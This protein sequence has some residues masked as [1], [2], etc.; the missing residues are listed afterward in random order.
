[1]IDPFNG[2]FAVE[3]IDSAIDLDVVIIGAPF[4]DEIEFYSKGAKKG[5]KNIRKSSQ[6]FSGQGLSQNS[7]HRLNVLDWG[8]IAATNDYEKFQK[9]LASKV[10]QILNKKA[11]SLIIG[12]DHSIALGTA[13][14]IKQS[15][16]SIDAIIWLDA[17][18]DLMEKFPETNRFSRAT[19]LKRILE[20]KIVKP[21]NVYIIGVR[22]HNLGWEEIE[23]TEE[24]K[25]KIL[26]ADKVANST[27][28]NQFIRDIL[29]KH[30]KLYVSLD[31][32]VLDPAFAPGVSVPEPGGI[33]SRELFEVIELL[34]KNIICF[35]IVEVNPN[36]D[37]NNITSKVACKAIFHFCDFLK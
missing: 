32:D 29:H 37:Y 5:T 14:G 23:Y 9:E 28:R 15:N 18:L 21:E 2:T 3:E 19:V 13:K 25:I 1:M 8:D 27:T 16:E 34:A 20:L 35:E 12:G 10:E 11:I 33:T 24:H 4:E 22:G 30:K 36:L 7:I 17:H 31:I 26:S 6:F